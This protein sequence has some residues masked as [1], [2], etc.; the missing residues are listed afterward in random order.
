ML[1]PPYTEDN[2]LLIFNDTETYLLPVV[3]PFGMINF[4][5]EITVPG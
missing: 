1:D 4:I 2:P 5:L 3:F